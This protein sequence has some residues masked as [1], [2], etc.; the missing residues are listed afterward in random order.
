MSGDH[1]KPATGRPGGQGGQ[2]VPFPPANDPGGMGS[3]EAFDRLINTFER[4]AR[5]WEMIV[6][7]SIIMLIVL[8]AGAF[9][10]IYSLTRDMRGMVEAMQPEMGVHLGRVAE[11][12]SQLTTS[13][14]NMSR[15]IDTMRMRIEAMSTDVGKISSQMVY[16]QNLQVMT[17]QMAEMNQAIHVMTAHTDSLRWNMQTMNRQISR[18]MSMMNSFMPW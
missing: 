6:Y 17:Q 14:D 11:S 5:R 12:V 18:P 13:L 15:N 2:V 4:S 3:V 1:E 7:P 10:F 9:F 8:A 16:M